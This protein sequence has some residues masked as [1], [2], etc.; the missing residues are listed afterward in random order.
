MKQANEMAS[1]I[2]IEKKKGKRGKDKKIKKETPIPIPKSNHE[3]FKK[4]E[5]LEEDNDQEEPF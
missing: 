3:L 2:K 4:E 5:K 1:A